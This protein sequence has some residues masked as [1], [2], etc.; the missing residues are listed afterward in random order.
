MIHGKRIRERFR[1]DAA[2]V[3]RAEQIRNQYREEGKSA[4]AMPADLR[5]EAFKCAK[6]LQPYGEGATLSKCVDHYVKTVLA[7][8]SAPR[9]N[10]AGPS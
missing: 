8:R 7:Y 2:A 5:I 1:T 6:K 10:H 3:E 4:F 9:R